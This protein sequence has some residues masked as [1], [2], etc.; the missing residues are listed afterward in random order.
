MVI[1]AFL[2]AEVS[3][4]GRVANVLCLAALLQGAAGL[5]EWR[6]FQQV[7]GLQHALDC[8][9]IVSLVRSLNASAI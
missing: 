1:L 4:A 3:C 5:S 8:V 9:C 6:R 2:R 7:N